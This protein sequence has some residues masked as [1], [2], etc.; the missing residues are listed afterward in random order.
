MEVLSIRY[1]CLLDFKPRCRLTTLGHTAQDMYKAFHNRISSVLV[2]QTL[3]QR[4][5]LHLF[6]RDWFIDTGGRPERYHLTRR[7]FVD[8]IYVMADLWTE[9]VER[10]KYSRF[11]RAMLMH[12]EDAVRVVRARRKATKFDPSRANGE[13]L[14]GR[15]RSQWAQGAG[16]A[17]AKFLKGIRNNTETVGVVGMQSSDHAA[18]IRQSVSLR[19]TPPPHEPEEGGGSSE[20]Q[21]AERNATSDVHQVGGGEDVFGSMAASASDALQLLVSQGVVEA[22]G[23]G[24]SDG[25]SADSV[26]SEGR[27]RTGSRH[28]R[29]MS[30]DGKL[31]PPSLFMPGSRGLEGGDPEGRSP[32]A[33]D[34]LLRSAGGSRVLAGVVEEAE[35]AKRSGGVYK[36]TGGGSSLVRK[37]SVNMLAGMEGG[38]G[39]YDRGLQL[40]KFLNDGSGSPLHRPTHTQ[41][42]M[43]PPWQRGKLYGQGGEGGG[44]SA[45]KLASVVDANKWMQNGDASSDSGGAADGNGSD[46]RE[47]TVLTFASSGDGG[48]GGARGLRRKGFKPPPG[49]QPSQQPV[50]VQTSSGEGEAWWRSA[51]P[52]YD[53][54]AQGTAG[55]GGS[56]QDM[57]RS[58]PVLRETQAEASHTDSHGHMAASA[59]A[60]IKSLKKRQ[61]ERFRGTRGMAL[62]GTEGGGSDSPSSGS[63]EGG[64]EEQE[65]G[66]ND[67]SG[68]EAYDANGRKVR[69]LQGADFIQE[70]GGGPRGRQ[71]HP[72]DDDELF[73][74]DDTSSLEESDAEG[75]VETMEMDTPGVPSSHRR[76]RRT[77]SLDSVRASIAKA[78]AEAR[79]GMGLDPSDVGAGGLQHA[80][81]GDDEDL[82]WDFG[83]G[84]PAAVKSRGGM[85][86]STTSN[87][88][89]GAGK[90][91]AN[92]TPNSPSAPAERESFT[93][94]IKREQAA[95]QRKARKRAQDARSADAASLMLSRTQAANALAN[96]A[97]EASL[98]AIQRLM[99]KKSGS[100]FGPRAMPGSTEAGQLPWWARGGSVKQ[101]SAAVGAVGG[102]P[103]LGGDS[104]AA[105]RV[106]ERATMWLKRNTLL[107]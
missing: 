4:D 77:S 45:T 84:G 51:T 32:D 19:P 87:R 35:E 62:R 23:G 12:V 66:E 7:Q 13:A 95:L 18:T 10:S 75:R 102:V 106:S 44:D 31:M 25:D 82:A 33:Q 1:V 49:E 64:L 48:E 67:V 57:A 73:D 58:T 52:L 61:R 90:A 96:A 17:V 99:G 89:A 29:G 98:P 21:Q 54:T 59:S 74:A 83:V 2:V 71:E 91:D 105:K 101:A 76:H 47:E 16:G 85:V 80:G 41:S 5:R 27:K 56:S 11:L 88:W 24:D 69:Q 53:E 22:L 26:R 81:D 60:D 15:M 42:F 34:R 68:D 38:E 28:T 43:I 79:W 14:W 72:S 86:G 37:P 93:S 55:E 103:R 78:Q 92:P 3:S 70:M 8:A 97:D 9:G 63:D 50:P 94:R 46:T 107:K 30:R 100:G 36:R 65:G 6:A 104:L 40:K 39:G 20:Q